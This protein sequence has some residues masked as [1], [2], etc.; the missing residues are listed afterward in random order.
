[1]GKVA[2]EEDEGGRRTKVWKDL[3]LGFFY[4]LGFNGE[5]SLGNLTRTVPCARVYG[6]EFS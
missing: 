5:T 6:V 3:V 1:M 2:K 4:S